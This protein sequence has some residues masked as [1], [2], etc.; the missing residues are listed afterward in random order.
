MGQMAIY[1]PIL[2]ALAVLIGAAVLLGRFRRVRVNSW[3][4]T[5]VYWTG[6]STVC[7]RRG[8][9]GCGQAMAG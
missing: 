2:M 9:I 1:V 5:A 8:C 3:E 4:R 6:R 7:W